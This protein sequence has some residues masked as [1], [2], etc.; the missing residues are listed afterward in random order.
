MV[1]PWLPRRLFLPT[2][3]RLFFRFP[4]PLLL[5]TRHAFLRRFSG[6]ALCLAA[7]NTAPKHMGMPTSPVCVVST[8]M[9]TL[10]EPML[11]LS[12][13]SSC[14]STASLTVGFAHA[15]SVVGTTVSVLGVGLSPAPPVWPPQLPE[16][17]QMAPLLL[18]S[19]PHLSRPGR[20]V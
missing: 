13:L 7:P 1:R 12:R 20:H 5:H 15:L 8:S 6:G 14:I 17:G 3:L 19:M 18:P 10:W 16:L 9:A 11:E 2:A 4:L